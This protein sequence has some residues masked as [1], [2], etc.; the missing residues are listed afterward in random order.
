MK[1]MLVFEIDS[2]FQ[3]ATISYTSGYNMIILDVII[4][5]SSSNRYYTLFKIRLKY[6][7]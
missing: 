2:I 7:S 3:L 5:V 1:K 4:N 6:T